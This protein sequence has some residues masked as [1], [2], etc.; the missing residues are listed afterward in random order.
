M[1][2]ARLTIDLDAIKRNWSALDA[3]SAETC[4]TAA[5]IKADAYG[6]G[7]AKVAPALRDAGARSFFV[8]LAEEGVVA[9][10]ALGPEPDIFVFSGYM[11]GDRVAVQEAA[12]IPCLNSR[13]QV[14]QF[15]SDCPAMPF[16]LQV[17]SGM[18]RL[19]LEPADL[20]LVLID[21]MGHQPQL[22]MS[23]LACADTPQAMQNQ[24]QAA[25][26]QT[27]TLP[28]LTTRR[29]LAATG[30]TVMGAGFHFDLTRPGIGLYGG[31]PFADAE[32]VVSLSLPVIQSRTVL[33]G[34]F[35]GYGATYTATEPRR[36]ATVAA[37]YADGLMRAIGDRAKLYCGD[38]PCAMVGRVSM[39]LITVDVTG[40][41][42]A[43]QTLDMLGPHQGIDAL[44]E[45]AGTIGYEILT[46]L[47]DRYARVYKGTQTGE[48]I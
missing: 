3:L 36:I 38:T 2:R 34:E 28:L 31:L 21:L 7:V 35:V 25:A 22:V 47:G 42:D 45:T 24:V 6:L 39:D 4:E 13:E 15:R 30:G 17:D 33:P 14:R 16:A 32:P 29:S 37:G 12:L 26:F 10:A 44:A 5:V 11:T 1:A 27:V 40:L 23:H 41:Q 9:R 43:P 20:A 19:G 18:N 46:S 8:A 48:G